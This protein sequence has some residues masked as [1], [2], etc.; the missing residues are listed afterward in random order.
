MCKSTNYYSDMLTRYDGIHYGSSY[1]ETLE[2]FSVVKAEEKTIH[3]VDLH[4]GFI[5][6][7]IGVGAQL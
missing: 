2:L 6:M 4:D 1:F 3:A 5:A 7:A